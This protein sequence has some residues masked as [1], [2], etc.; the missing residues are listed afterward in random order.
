VG[1]AP[2]KCSAEPIGLQHLGAKA[3]RCQDH[4]RLSLVL[5]VSEQSRL[6]WAANTS[7][8]SALGISLRGMPHSAHHHDFTSWRQ[9]RW[10]RTNERPH[11]HH[12]RRKPGSAS[13]KPPHEKLRRCVMERSWSMW[14]EA[15]STIITRPTRVCA[16]VHVR[17]FHRLSSCSAA[18]TSSTS[19]SGC[20]SHSDGILSPGNTRVSSANAAGMTSNSSRS[21]S[22]GLQFRN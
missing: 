21:S 22:D 14:V 1:V 13:R 9:R 8:G 7:A 5:L 17:S 10:I 15:L 20:C 6:G 19:S 16:C 4:H 11:F 2:C 3:G 12:H 18:P